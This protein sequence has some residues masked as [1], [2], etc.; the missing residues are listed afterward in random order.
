MKRTRKKADVIGDVRSNSAA[1][2]PYCKD[3]G[4]E[5][6]P[7]EKCLTYVSKYLKR[8]MFI[9]AECLKRGSEDV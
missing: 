5:I 7:G 4:K 8:T 9:C 1:L 2:Y 6:K 3:C